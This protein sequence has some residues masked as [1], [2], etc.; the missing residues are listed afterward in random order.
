MPAVG[1]KIPP[2]EFGR[3]DAFLLWSLLAE[4]EGT[5]AYLLGLPEKYQ[6]M[7]SAV[8]TSFSRAS[9]TW[10]TFWQRETFRAAS[11]DIDYDKK[12]DGHWLKA[13]LPTI[14]DLKKT[15]LHG[16]ATTSQSTSNV[17]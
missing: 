4:V 3:E 8:E 10:N 7:I 12:G 14:I 2:R 11:S 13:G 17:L 15:D 1:L 9:I 6:G 5:D 16:R